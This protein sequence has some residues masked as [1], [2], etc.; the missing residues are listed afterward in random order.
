MT[1]TEVSQLLVDLYQTVKQ[2]KGQTKER[3]VAIKHDKKSGTQCLRRKI[4]GTALKKRLVELAEKIGSFIA[5]GQAGFIQFSIALPELGRCRVGRVHF[6]SVPILPESVTEKRHAPQPLLDQS[7]EGSAL[8]RFDDRL[9]VCRVE[10][11]YLG[12]LIVIRPKP[13]LHP[14]SEGRFDLPEL[15]ALKAGSA[16]EAGTEVEKIERRH[17]F[18]D[19]HLLV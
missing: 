1:V 12:V 17:R 16:F 11:A 9:V 3:L 8:L 2:R 7:Q 10:T 4:A 6:F 14:Q 5:L 18:Q 13:V 19:V 15:G